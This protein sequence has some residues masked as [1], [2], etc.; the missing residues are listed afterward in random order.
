MFIA[1][2]R[3]GPDGLVYPI[4]MD[5]ANVKIEVLPQIETFG[6]VRENAL[7]KQSKSIQEKYK[8]FRKGE[9]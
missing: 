8:N 1:K 9:R 4:Y 2:N 7:K 3:N 6:E 5:T